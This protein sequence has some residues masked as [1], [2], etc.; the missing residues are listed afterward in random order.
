MKNKLFLLI[1]LTFLF[2]CNIRIE[3]RLYNK[4]YYVDVTTKHDRKMTNTDE[5]VINNNPLTSANVDNKSILLNKEEIVSKNENVLHTSLE[6]NNSIPSSMVHVSFNQNHTNKISNKSNSHSVIT[7]NPHQKKERIFTDLFTGT[8][9][10]NTQLFM[11]AAAMGLIIFGAV[12][13]ARKKTLKLT[14]WANKYKIATK[15]MIGALQTASIF[16]GVEIGKELFDFGYTFSNSVEYISGAITIAGMVGLVLTRR[17]DKIM[18]MRQFNIK[19]LSLVAIVMSSFVLTA[20]I[21]NKI[22]DNR[23][24]ISLLGHVAE[25]MDNA[26]YKNTTNYQTKQKSDSDIEK[27]HVQKIKPNHLHST[28]GTKAGRGLLALWIFLYIIMA[29]ALIVG[30]CALFCAQVYGAAI[31]LLILGLAAMIIVP[32]YMAKWASNH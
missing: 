17:K 16:M 23:K 25:K 30:I 31:P 21:G 10:A 20:A 13:A 32:I 14:R 1:C 5:V 24:Q 29:L 7:A 26:I 28:K 8:Q 19:K 22:P 2:S 11:L 12:K 9:Q 15:L 27:N 4:G 6:E 3:K 18:S